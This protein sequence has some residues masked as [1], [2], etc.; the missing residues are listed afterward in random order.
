MP[1]GFQYR[2]TSVASRGDPA[3]HFGWR[4]DIGGAMILFENQVKPLANAGCVTHILYP[5]DLFNMLFCRFPGPFKLHFGAEPERL[6]HFWG[7]FLL[8][9]YGR[10]ASTKL[11]AL[12]GKSP[13]EL[14]HCIPLIVHGDGC[15]VTKKLSAL[16]VQWGGMLGSRLKSINCHKASRSPRPA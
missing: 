10:E 11:A 8:T 13:P 1:F 2:S 3:F 12:R 15:P 16:F 6:E 14:D 7:K 5:H 9:A 4:G